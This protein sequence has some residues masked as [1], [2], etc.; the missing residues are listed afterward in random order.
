MNRFLLPI[1][2]FL[3]ASSAS[4]Q[5]PREEAGA[6]Y[7]EEAIFL[8]GIEMKLGMP[9]SV[10]WS[11]L[12]G[13]YKLANVEADIWVIEEI[14]GPPHRLIGGL[15]FKD[16]KLSWISKDW[17][18]SGRESSLD[19]AKDLFSLLANLA[20]GGKGVA[21]I[22]TNTVRQPG[23]TLYHLSLVFPGR[24]ILINIVEDRLKGDSI[25]MQEV[26]D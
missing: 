9:K 25:S 6:D 19:F 2:M 23:L 12:E 10:I 26:I 8:A 13:K 18:G 7:V 16:G 24:R 21:M 11:A 17:G 20:E 15:A 14:T 22:E 5:P 4:S 1:L 3:I